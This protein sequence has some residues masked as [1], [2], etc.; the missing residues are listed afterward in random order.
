MLHTGYAYRPSISTE[1]INTINFDPAPTYNHYKESA[2]V[3]AA[4]NGAVL[5]MIMPES[6]FNLANTDI[7]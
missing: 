4:D 1:V 2:Q 5:S 3:V 7:E 6:T